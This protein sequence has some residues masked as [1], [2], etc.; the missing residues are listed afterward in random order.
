MTVRVII[1]HTQMEDNGF[2]IKKLVEDNVKVYVDTV[3][4]FMA[5]DKLV[6]IDNRSIVQG[7]V[8]WSAHALESA[9]KLFIFADKRAVDPIVQDFRDVLLTA[10]RVLKEEVSKF[11]V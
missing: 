6:I 5:H 7:S 1:D 4:R 8:N 9:G 3:D 10:R 11:I 2:Q